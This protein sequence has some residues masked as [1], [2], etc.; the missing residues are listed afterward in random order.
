MLT[1]SATAVLLDLRRLQRQSAQADPATVAALLAAAPDETTGPGVLAYLCADA[2][3]AASEA[4]PVLLSWLK[5]R[6]RRLCLE[7]LLEDR[8]LQLLLKEEGHPP[9]FIPCLERGEWH[10]L[11]S[12]SPFPVQRSERPAR[13]RLAWFS[14]LPPQRSGI[15]DYSAALIPQL[16]E[17][18][19]IDVVADPQA[20]PLPAGAGAL[21]SPEEFEAEA[22]SYPHLLFQLGNSTLHLRDLRF[23]R[24]HSGAV[25]MH[26]F[27]LSHGFCADEADAALG[28][29]VMERLYRSHGFQACH[30]RH[31]DQLKGGDR[32]IWRYPCNLDPLQW[33]SGVIVHSREA[34]MLAESFYGLSSASEW[35]VVPHLKHVAP[36]AESARWSARAEL[37]LPEHAF[38]L[39]S[40]GFLGVAKLT[41]RLLQGFLRSSLATDPGVVFVFAGSDAGNLSL[42]LQLG[43]ALAD[44]TRRGTLRAEVRFTGWIPPSTYQR[45]L[46]AADGAVQLRTSSRGETSG[47]VLDAMG[48]GVP[49]IVNDHGSMREL[50]A[51]A[52]LRL[53]DQCTSQD[54]A[55][56]LEQL[57]NDN[58]LRRRLSSA[59]L[60]H[61]A[62]NH[63]PVV[64]A[65]RYA[66]AIRAASAKRSQRRSWLEAAAVAVQAGACPVKVAN[67]LALLQPPHPS[68]RQ[69]FLDV[70]V[71]A[72]HD[73]GSGVQRVVRAISEQLLLHPP[74]GFRV[75]PVRFSDDGQGFVYARRFALR[76]LGIPCE[77]WQEAPI[78]PRSGDVFLGIDLDQAGVV[79]R[80]A[81]F[82]L[83]R[84]VGVDVHFVVHDLLP[85][86]QPQYFPPGAGDWHQAWLKVVSRCD[87]ALCVSRSVADDLR[88]WLR[89]QGLFGDDTFSIRW[90]H[91]GSDF[92]PADVGLSPVESALLQQI[93]EGTTLLMVGTVEPRKGYLDVIEAATHLWDQGSIFNLVI[94]G[95][96]GWVD[97]PQSQRR[98][99][100]ATVMRLRQH[101]LR[102]RR[103]FWFEAASDALLHSLYGRA[104]GLISASYGEGFGIPLVEAAR[105]GLSLLVR[106]LPVFREVTEGR[107]S[108]FSEKADRAELSTA[109]DLFLRRLEA[110]TPEG[111]A[112][113][114]PCQSWRQS[115]AQLVHAL[116][117]I[118]QE[119]PLE[120]VP[121]TQSESQNPS[122]SEPPEQTA[123][124]PVGLLRQG[125]RRLR[126]LKSSM[127]GLRHGISLLLRLPPHEY[128][129][130]FSRLPARLY[131]RWRAM[132]TRSHPEVSLPEPDGHMTPLLEAAQPWLQDLERSLD[133]HPPASR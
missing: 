119:G 93:P 133:S 62:E 90:F 49:L 12:D 129:R 21:L 81:T 7:P 61:V 104:Q 18:F 99:I 57:R 86:L 33:A 77:D 70:T 60:A 95:K 63:D 36:T 6:R 92:C 13:E 128:R 23:L 94:V 25:V 30:L 76:L 68:Q 113:K 64:C 15:G 84:S 74:Q 105:A 73:L 56:G 43:L 108:F 106:D 11:N 96:E 78:H 100:P 46:E 52:V 102:D 132:R 48:A 22:E 88:Q 51:H 19:E 3:W 55:R 89:D 69:L 39:C 31:Q 37:S 26:D 38:V 67:S 80:Q 50:P 59:S 103:L 27:F 115:T 2:D 1:S 125:R 131:R 124:V 75:E 82:Q 32:A 114:L 58:E 66:D 101:P 34:V 41:D 118:W 127:R 5:G 35:S 85:C 122:E 71:V 14:P 45:Y 20:T 98:T 112:A 29:D 53:P 130:R 121:P 40:F 54:I 83:L 65:Q 126:R 117:L 107:A 24:R 10:R 91:H 9:C 8:L 123:S 87:G 120:S 109:I 17:F 16:A 4:A 111:E 72:R 47:T 116:G 97:L 110:G 42:R 28:G 79:Q 44:A